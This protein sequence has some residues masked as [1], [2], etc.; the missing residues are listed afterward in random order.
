MVINKMKEPD[1]KVINQL[2]KEQKWCEARNL[3]FKWAKQTKNNHWELTRIASTYAEEK[4]YVQALKYAAQALIITPDC[5]LTLW[6][7]A[8]I[9]YMLHR[10]KEA[11]RLYKHLIRLGVEHAAHGTCGQG[12]RWARMTI[13]DSR[14]HLGLVYARTGQFRLAAKYIKQYI[15]N[16]DR[17]THSIYKIREVKKDLED[18]LKGRD[19]RED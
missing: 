18:V 4:D 6:D 9:L 10:N 19:P 14:Y 8:G 5:P 13:N 1:S 16:R 17:N 15:K 2:F 7:N 3:L 12:V 11:A